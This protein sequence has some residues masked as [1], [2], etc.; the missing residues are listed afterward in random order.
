MARPITRRHRLALLFN[1]PPRERERERCEEGRG[2]RG[3]LQVT[4]ELRLNAF[5]Q[6]RDRRKGSAGVE[7]QWLH[8]REE[9][10]L[11]GTPCVFGVG[12]QGQ[13]DGEQPQERVKSIA[14][15]KKKKKRKGVVL[16]SLRGRRFA[17]EIESN[18]ILNSVTGPE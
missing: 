6:G 11:K 4:G 5:T 13:R 14:K 9:F 2:P 17:P 16:I 8:L 12:H 3:S 15:K 7:V 18:I 10:P 1:W